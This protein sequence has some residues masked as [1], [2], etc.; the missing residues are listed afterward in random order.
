MK[1]FGLSSFCL[2]LKVETLMVTMSSP[3]CVN[4][5]LVALDL[6]TG[7]SAAGLLLEVAVMTPSGVEAF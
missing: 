1:L 3:L 6:L 7:E 4:T 5:R 2:V